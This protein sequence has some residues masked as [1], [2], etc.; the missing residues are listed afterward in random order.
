MKDFGFNLGKMGAMEGVSKKG[1]GCTGILKASLLLLSGDETTAGES[2]IKEMVGQ[3]LQPSRQWVDQI[4]AGA[5]TN[6]CF[7]GLW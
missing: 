1:S 3:R 2:G 6:M 7:P 5:K 4:R